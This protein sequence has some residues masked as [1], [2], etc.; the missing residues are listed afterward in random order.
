MD[1]SRLAPE[2][3]DGAKKQRAVQDAK[4]MYQAVLRNC[5]RTNTPI[6]PFEFFELIGKGG[7]GRVY[8]CKDKTTGNLVAVKIISVDD[9]DYFADPLDKDDTIRDF[10]KE[11]K[12]L[13]QLKDS[14]AKNVNMIHDAFDLQQQL[15]IVCDYCTGGSVRTLMRARPAGRPGLEEKF[16]I[17]IARELAVAMKSV[18]NLEIIH[19]DIKCTNV[20]ITETGEIQLG[21]FGIV[22][23][24]DDGNSKRRTVIGT[25]HYMPREMLASSRS[26]QT[27][28]AYGQEVDVWSFGCSVYEMATGNP[29]N[30]TMH[31]DTLARALAN[32][33]RLEGGDHSVELRDFVAFC[34]N[35]DPRQ[36][37]TSDAVLKHPYIADSQR[38]YPTSSLIELIANYKLWEYG[39]G[40]RQSLF[41]PGGAAAPA[42]STDGDPRPEEEVEFDDWNFSTSDGFNEALGK[43]FSQMVSMQHPNGFPL[44]AHAG[45]GLPPI[46]TR[47]L[48]PLE[49]VQEVHKELSANRGERSLERL[50][51]DSTAPYELHTPTDDPIRSIIDDLPLRNTAP[52]RESTI[53]I[54]LDSVVDM[55]NN[56]PAINF[57]FGDT[58]KARSSRVPSGTDD[59][60]NDFQ[61]VQSDEDREKRATLDWKFPSQNQRP[62]TMEWTFPKTEP[63]EPEDPDGKMGLPSTG[64]GGDLPPG[65]RP[66]FMHATTEPIG[67]FRD[68]VL[69]TP[70]LPS[71][72]ASPVRDSMRPMIDLDF[73][74]ADPSEIIRP[75][76]ATSATGSTMTDM[77]S[78]NPFD[79]EDDPEQ[80]EM[81]RDRFSYHKQWQSEGGQVSRNSRQSVPM[82]T[83]GSSLSS[84]ESELDRPGVD[85][86]DMF[87]Y[88]YGRKLSDTMRHQMNGALAHDISDIDQWPSFGSESTYDRI[89][90]YPEGDLE[91]MSLGPHDLNATAFEQPLR[92]NGASSSRPRDRSTSRMGG[93]EIEFPRLEA[94]NP[95]ALLE[96]AD[97]N[98][99]MSEL[100]RMLDDFHDSLRVTSKVLQRHSGLEDENGG[101]SENSSAVES[102]APPTGDEDGF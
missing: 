40:I 7:S 83:R 70:Q 68:F 33:P 93:P 19:R 53:M 41:M 6:P 100:E 85:D 31:P 84:T 56:V 18:H 38:Q 34:L 39:G 49:K 16:I 27:H 17:P 44:Q 86:D 74:L 59:D 14:Q 48:T 99:V 22:G 25:P 28:E 9:V 81:D 5:E 43:R 64:D 88:D 57:D 75:S 63:K 21:D 87:G 97:S 60:D 55:E 47:D 29:P 37:P 46:N 10:R 94:P 71:A 35:S 50:F 26:N 23:V 52:T 90:G 62:Q 82:H 65:L 66:M 2:S 96:D 79:L 42:P 8:K 61:Y 58:I 24:M 12:I 4:D 80:N 72:S 76:T 77:T 15:W 69:P 78:G 36:R 20:Y 51:N 11:V 32:A 89:S 30:P 13:N 91:P 98:V 92:L 54:D 101:V 67:Q 3:V 45:S 1:T 73:G 102:S 95:N